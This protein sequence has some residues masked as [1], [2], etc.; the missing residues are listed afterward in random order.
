M[1]AMVPRSIPHPVVGAGGDGV[2]TLGVGDDLRGVQGVAQIVDEAAGVAAGRRGGPGRPGQRPGPLTLVEVPRQGAG[3]DRFGDAGHGRAQ[4]QGLLHRS[5]DRLWT[6]TVNPCRAKFRARLLPITPSPMTPTSAFIFIL[7][8]ERGCSGV[9][10]CDGHGAGCGDE[11]FQF[12]GD[13][14]PGRLVHDLGDP[15]FGE[16][17]EVLGEFGPLIRSGSWPG[18]PPNCRPP[19]PPRRPG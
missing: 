9:R 12:A 13:V 3:E 8:S 18:S 1:L 6:A 15:L 5:I 10:L 11:R 19:R 14:G 2:E 16:G 7:S 4:F 17:A